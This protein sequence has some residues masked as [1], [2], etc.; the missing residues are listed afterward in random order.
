[1]SWRDKI[2]KK[3]APTSGWRAKAEEVRQQ[4][5]TAKEGAGVSNTLMNEPA[6]LSSWQRFVAKSFAANPNRAAAYIKSKNP[7]LEVDVFNGEVVVRKK[8]ERNFKAIDPNTLELADLGELAPDVVAGGLQSLA[9]TAAAIPAGVATGGWGALPAAMAASGASG[10]ALETARLGIGSALGIPDN[11]KGENIATAG[12]FGLATPALFGVDNLPQSLQQSGRGFLKRGVDKVGPGLTEFFT[13]IDPATQAYYRANKST[14][15]DIAKGGGDRQLVASGGQKLFDYINEARTNLLERAGDIQRNA[16]NV[17]AQQVGQIIK[18]RIKEIESNPKT[19]L[20]EQ[21]I[22]ETLKKIYNDNFGLA[23]PVKEELVNIPEAQ[24]IYSQ[25][26]EVVKQ[27]PSNQAADF[28]FVDKNLPAKA[29]IFK[30]LDPGQEEFLTNINKYA[31]GMVDEDKA[32]LQKSAN[33]LAQASNLKEAAN[34]DFVIQKNLAKLKELQDKYTIRELGTS[35]PGDVM[36]RLKQRLKGYSPSLTSTNQDPQA[37]AV[38]S[39]VE[40]TINKAY[41]EGVNKAFD[42]ATSGASTAANKAAT[43]FLSPLGTYNVINNKITTK[44]VLD[45]QKTYQTLVGLGSPSKRNIL[46]EIENLRN[47]GKLDFEE[48]NQMRALN[49]FYGPSE[50]S[51]LIG[52]D[53]AQPRR[54][55]I[56]TAL[57]GVGSLL[58]YKLGGG[59]AGAALGGGAGVFGGKGL[60]SKAAARSYINLGQA[61]DALSNSR[62]TNSPLLNPV[63]PAL[64][65]WLYQ[66]EESP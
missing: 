34:R 37:A 5:E 65:P 59:Y 29:D 35:E 26:D 2:E 63:N 66:S 18:D 21:R 46:G 33:E 54:T 40:R 14:I 39:I 20:A 24:A 57:G 10:A 23:Y 62:I 17:N 32:A 16:K 8:G 28:S 50:D 42:E 64:N 55:A 12:A 51:F 52:G 1:M 56:S 19:V 3:Q 9:T 53:V 25:L 13:N 4:L 44:G 45:P 38:N 36:L 6:D 60:S 61:L 31:R 7:N 30:Y 22:A 47:L 48:P 11:I 43:E 58:G 41:N 15:Q 27:K 49:A